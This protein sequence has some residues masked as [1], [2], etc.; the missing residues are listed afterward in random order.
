MTVARARLALVWSPDG[1]L[2]AIGGLDDKR[3]A[4]STVEMLDCP[5]D[6]EGD[7][8]G[9]WMPVAPMNRNRQFHGA[10]FFE[11]KIF[12]AGGSGEDSVECFDMPSVG[13]PNGQW[14]MIRPM[15]RKAVLQ[16]ILPFGGSL[17]MVGELG[18]IY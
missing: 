9:A 12:V 4:T 10:C 1:R 7:A 16:G 2:F 17:L 18:S 11:D 13:I 5:W 14:T 8:G 6:T 15:T 3:K